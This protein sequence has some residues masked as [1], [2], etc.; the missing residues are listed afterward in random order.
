M[1]I[2]PVYGKDTR[3]KCIFYLYFILMGLCFSFLETSVF[4]VLAVIPNKY[5]HL[6][7]SIEVLFGITLVLHMYLW[8]SDPGFLKKDDSINYLEVLESVDTHCI[9]PDCKLIKPP[10]AR[11]CMKCNRC[12]DRFDHH[13]AWI[14]ICIG[15]NN[16]KF[17]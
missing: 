13:C 4:K 5:N 6:I 10:R 3:P 14:N 16:L 15:R 8:M 11:H 1:Q 12:V 7:L 2:T 17:F 9:C